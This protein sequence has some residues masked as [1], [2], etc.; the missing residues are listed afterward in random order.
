MTNILIIHLGLGPCGI[1]TVRLYRILQ[2][3]GELN[4]RNLHAEQI[5]CADIKW[6]DVAIFIRSVS[7]I[8]LHLIKLFRKYRKY[9]IL[10]MDDDLL[11]LDDNY[12]KDGE[13]FWGARKKILNRILFH[14]DCLIA[15]NEHLANKYSKIGNIPKTVLVNTMVEDDEFFPDRQ[16][17]T[18]QQI[19][20]LV[21]YVN[22][23]TIE[24]F[25][26][27]IRPVLPKLAKKYPQK[28]ELYLLALQPNISEISNVLKIIYVSHMPYNEFK[29]YMGTEPFD[30]GLA[31]LLDTGFS[32]YK[33]FNKYI[34]Y[35]LAGIPAIYS[36]CALYKKVIK[37]GENGIL[38]ENTVEGWYK[39]IC[40]LIDSP[41]T[42]KQIITNAQHHLHENFSC[43]SNIEHLKKEIPQLCNY[44]TPN[45]CIKMLSLKLFY[46]K[47]YY[48]VFRLRGWCYILKTYL[49]N[50]KFKALYRRFNS[51]FIN[52]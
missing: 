45:V 24:M 2:D 12:G 32:V 39:A 14:V 41:L 19:V 50:G 16:K 4:M 29:H 6:C 25:D 17:C 8:E 52:K 5:A 46:I 33:Y 36:N 49:K 42:R 43:E 15:V 1:E 9:V 13:G 27:I 28:I 34:E 40:S 35:T 10:V 7:S 37:N 31:P 23:G 3:R 18:N 30:I 48:K 51:H 11:N 38:C 47:W 26:K 20:R 21:L 22:D 44:K